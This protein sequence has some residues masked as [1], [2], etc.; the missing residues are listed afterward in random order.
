MTNNYMFNRL[1]H[2]TGCGRHTDIAIE[3]FNLGDITATKSLIKGWRTEGGNRG[4]F[5]PDHVLD[6]FIAGLFKYRDIKNE[7]GINLFYSQ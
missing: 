1:L 4:T 3:V 5:M 2:L 7:K 6:G